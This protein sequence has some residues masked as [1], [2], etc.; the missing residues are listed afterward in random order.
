[1][2]CEHRGEP[3]VGRR[4]FVFPLERGLE[5]AQREQTFITGLLY[6]EEPRPILSETLNA[7]EKPLT[8]M[9]DAQLRPTKDAL[10]NLMKDFM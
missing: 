4:P 3:V 2:G 9:N 5:E 7:P 8:Q 1:M 10:D 6:Y